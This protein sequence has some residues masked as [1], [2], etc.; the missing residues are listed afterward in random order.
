[1]LASDRLEPARPR[2]GIAIFRRFSRGGVREPVGP[3][4]A[5][6]FAKAGACGLQ[7]FVERRAAQRPAGLI[8]L[9]RPGDGVVPRIGLQRARAHPVRVVVV[10]AEAADVHRP[11]IER[12]LAVGDPFGERHA[13]AARRGDA[14]GVEAGADEEIAHL[15]RLAEHEIAVRREA[16]QAVDH[17]LDAGRRQRRDA[18][19]RQAHDRLEMIP[20]VGQKAKGEILGDG[21]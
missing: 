8:F 11:E 4:E 5:D 17:L 21:A 20:I 19:E 10:R 7:A 2:E 14:E 16:L 3:L 12:R 18:P 13:G 9:R 6:L 15:R 1:M